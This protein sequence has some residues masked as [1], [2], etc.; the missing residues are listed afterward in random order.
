MFN[1]SEFR[2]CD[3]LINMNSVFKMLDINYVTK[4]LDE[5]DRALITRNFRLI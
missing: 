1:L 4:K 3:K 2:S 5:L